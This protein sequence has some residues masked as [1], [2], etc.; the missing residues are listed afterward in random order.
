M[1]HP[2]PRT[3]WTPCDEPPT[4]NRHV[5]VWHRVR[6]FCRYFEPVIGWFNGADWRTDDSNFSHTLIYQP[7]LWKDID[8]PRH[9]DFPTWA[10]LNF[11]K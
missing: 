2:F 4:S 7:V 5:I 1:R 9:P 11:K 8:E 3:D 6:P 10:D